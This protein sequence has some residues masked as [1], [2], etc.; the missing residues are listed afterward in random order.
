MEHGISGKTTIGIE[1]PYFD[2]TQ[3]CV[4]IGP[5]LFFPDDPAEAIKLKVLVKPLCDSC[6]FK[7]A[8][9]QWALDNDEVG[10]WGGTTDRDRK[11]LRRRRYR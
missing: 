7:L 11:E 8:C 9:L 10:I 3:P 5:E 2:G 1:A 4:G 6:S